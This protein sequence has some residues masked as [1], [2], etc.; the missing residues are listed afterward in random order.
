MPELG[1]PAVDPRIDRVGVEVEL[2]GAPAK[3]VTDAFGGA[4]DRITVDVVEDD[5]PAG[6]E[7]DLGDPGAH[8]P[9]AHDADDRHTDFIASNGWRQPLQ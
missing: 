7:R 4:L 8:H 2:R 5:L 9:G 1:D 6:L 3:S